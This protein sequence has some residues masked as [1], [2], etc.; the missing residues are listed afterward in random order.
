[1]LS[2]RDIWNNYRAENELREKIRTSLAEWSRFALSPL[3]QQPARHHLKL[4]EELEAVSRGEVDRL[5]VLMPPGAAKST[6][7]SVLFP[8]WWFIQHP[9]SSVIGASHTADLAAHFSRQIRNMVKEH[10]LR[11]GY[12]LAADQRNAMSWRNDRRGF[13]H[14]AGVRGPIVGRRADLVIID[15]PIKSQSEAD[16]IGQRD[17]VWSWYR[18]ELIPRLKPRGRIVIVMTRWHEDD[19]GGRLLQSSETWRSLCL[20]ALALA[21]DPLGRSP[22]EPIWPEWEDL[23]ALLRKRDMLGE[24]AWSALFQQ[25]PRPASAGIFT[26]ERIAFLEVEP[27]NDGL[28]VRAWDLAATSSGAG[29]NPD[30]TVGLKLMR[31]ASGQ[32]IV[33]DVMRLR[34]GPHEVEQ[35]IVSMAARDGSSVPIGLPQDPGQA[36][37]AQILYLTRKLAGYQVR[38]SPE[39]GPKLTRAM[40][41]AAQCGVAN[42]VVVRARWNAAFIDELQ[43]FPNGEKDDQVDALSRAFAM[44]TGGGAPA[45]ML[46]LPILAR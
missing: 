39:S 10:S 33:L 24:R 45:R 41:V 25:D 6:Y 38:A 3:A 1:M 46:R 21:E 30:W 4:I 28:T 12:A 36:G 20:P 8:A 44:L 15:D 29:R 7:T 31:S 17:N 27:V 40:P 23:A 22:G 43:V 37:R 35:A 14:S 5:I 34:G 18:S 9:N 13:Y 19:L 2:L 42:L 11:L 32:F 16:S 26:V